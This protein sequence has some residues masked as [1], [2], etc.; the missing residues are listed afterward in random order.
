MT[1]VEGG[2]AVLFYINEHI[3]CKINK[4]RGHSK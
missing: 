4:G 2:A 1:G 3:P